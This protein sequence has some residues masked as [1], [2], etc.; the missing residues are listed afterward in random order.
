MALRVAMRLIRTV[1]LS[2]F[3]LVVLSIGVIFSTRHEAQPNVAFGDFIRDVDA[4]KIEEITIS[5]QQ[6]SGIYRDDKTG[7]QT[8]I[9]ATQAD[10]AS[11]LLAKGVKIYARR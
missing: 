6:V 10:L 5:G 3:A 9:P 11:K 8:Y 4:G 2:L 7:F 1:K